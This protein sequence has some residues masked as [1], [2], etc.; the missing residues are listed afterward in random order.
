[1]DAALR[2]FV[3]DR[4]SNQCEY[5]RTSQDH[6]PF[7]RFHIEHIRPRQHDGTDEASNLA[8]ACHHCNLHKGPNLTAIDPVTAAIVSLFDPRRQAWSDHFAFQGTVINGL[9]PTGRAT[10]R[11]LKMNAVS[12]LELR[13]EAGAERRGRP[14]G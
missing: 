1:M 14:S 6:E 13:G 3:R 9:T 12:R 4:A 11:L 10:E 8:L 5:C 7:Y 2:K